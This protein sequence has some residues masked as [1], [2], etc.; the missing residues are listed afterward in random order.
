M[1]LKFVAR[2]FLPLMIVLLTLLSGCVKYD[3]RVNFKDQHHGEIVQTIILGQRLTTLNKEESEQ[4]LDSIE[5]RAKLLGGSAKRFSPEEVS[6]TIP[7]NSSRDLTKKFNQ[8][9][10]PTSN[11]ATSIAQGENSELL[12]LESKMITRQSNLIFFERNYINLNVDLR[13]LGVLS[14]QG[15]VIV[16]PGSLIDLEFS[17]KTPWAAKPLIT[18]NAEVTPVGNQLIWHLQP[19]KI[20]TL[21]AVFWLPSYLGIGTGIII[22]LMLLGY[23]FKYKRFPG[24]IGTLP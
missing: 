13:A 14:N 19:G 8:F 23:L 7:F 21:E 11:S 20:N 9:F 16:S 18:S 15:N 3:V 12:Q 22:V 5:Q 1:T 6:V 10:N 4:W 17:L 24:V 2:R